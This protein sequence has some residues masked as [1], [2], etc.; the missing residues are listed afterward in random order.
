MNVTF[1]DIIK[2]RLKI[3]ISNKFDFDF[4]MYHDPYILDENLNRIDE[5]AEL[6][7][8][9][10]LQGATDISLFGSLLF[11]FMP[12]MI[13]MTAYGHGSQMM[14]AS[15]IPWIILFLAMIEFRSFKVFIFTEVIFLKKSI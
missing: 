11:T 8:L 15:Y 13:T 12:Y 2:S 9:T 6:P 5:L 1:V 3:S 14:T 4:T 7:N 10:Y